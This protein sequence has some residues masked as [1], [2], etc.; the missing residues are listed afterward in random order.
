MSTESF[1][2]PVPG[3]SMRRARALVFLI[4]REAA[5]TRDVRDASV[6]TAMPGDVPVDL[7]SLIDATA[8]D[9]PT[10]TG[11][12]LHDLAEYGLA[13][14]PEDEV[15]GKALERA[16]PVWAPLVP[17][18]SRLRAQV[19]LL[20]LQRHTIVAASSPRLREALGADDP[21]VVAA[22]AQL[23][24]G[25]LATHYAEPSGIQ[26]LFAKFRR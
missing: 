4:E 5:R 25:D 20:L 9:L 12:S 6:L 13:R 3:E 2:L 19:L 21:S 7:S 1:D 22:F 23:G 14:R 16:A 8:M 17:D 10:P 18:N 11:D 24:H 15:N 26:K